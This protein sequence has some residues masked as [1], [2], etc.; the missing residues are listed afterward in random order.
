ILSPLRLPVPP[1]GRIIRFL[2]FKK[3]L[4]GVKQARGLILIGLPQKICNGK[5]FVGRGDATERSCRL[6]LLKRFKAQFA[7][8]SVCL[9]HHSG[10]QLF[11]RLRTKLNYYSKSAMFSQAFLKYFLQLPC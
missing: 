5:D 2:I 9:F 10:E 1:L 4:P 7:S 6:S 3:L 11:I 8:T